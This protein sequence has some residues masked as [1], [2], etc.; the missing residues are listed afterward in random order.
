MQSISFKT[1]LLFLFI[2]SLVVSN[3]QNISCPRFI[4]NIR[5]GE[6][7][8]E[9][10]SHIYPDFNTYADTRTASLFLTKEQFK[11]MLMDM[12]KGDYTIN[13]FRIFFALDGNKFQIVFTGLRDKNDTKVYYIINSNGTY[14]RIKSSTTNFNQ[15]SNK[16]KAYQGDPLRYSDT[17]RCDTCHICDT[18]NT[19]SYI[20]NKGVVYDIITELMR[21]R[22]NADIIGI[23]FKL[24]AYIDN[25][26]NPNPSKSDYTNRIMVGFTFIDS[27]NHEVYINELPAYN[28]YGCEIDENKRELLQQFLSPKTIHS[29]D[30]EK[31]VAAAAIGADTGTPCPPGS[32]CGNASLPKQ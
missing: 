19:S 15:L 20:F 21:Q 8:Q 27:N 30:E 9:N 22:D 2:F 32:G 4:I 23:R 3:G 31:A 10:F 5:T 14:S 18:C 17:A 12:V 6:V 28:K 11:N 13:G 1:L 24:G 16:I 29:F 25:D 7:L 26:M